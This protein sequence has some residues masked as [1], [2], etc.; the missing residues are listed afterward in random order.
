MNRKETKIR[1]L[2]VDIMSSIFK[3]NS[4]QIAYNNVGY[5]FP[6]ERTPRQNSEMVC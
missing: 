5:S 2:Y 6:V 3:V 4:I 1:Y